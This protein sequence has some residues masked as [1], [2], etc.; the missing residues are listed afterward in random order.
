MHGEGITEKAKKNV[1][2]DFGCRMK[3]KGEITRKDNKVPA[4]GIY[5][6]MFK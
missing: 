2:L 5:K 6:K 3:R 4:C 1:D